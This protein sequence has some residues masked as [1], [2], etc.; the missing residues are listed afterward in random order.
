VLDNECVAPPVTETQIIVVPRI[1]TISPWSS[2]AT[3]IAHRCNLTNVQRIERGVVFNLE[4]A[5]SLEATRSE[6]RVISLL[7]DRMTESIL[8]DHQQVAE[9]FNRDAP[10]P[11]AEIELSVD[12]HDRLQRAN[13]VLGLALSPDEIDYLL[14]AYRRLQRNPTDAELM[15]FAQ[16]NSEHCRHKIF[17]ASFTLDGVAQADSL[18]AM[19]RHT[20]TLSPAGVLSA[21]HDNSA[22]IEGGP[23]A[24][25]M[26]QADGHYAAVVEPVHIQIKVETHNHPTAISPFAGAA[27]GAGGEIRDEG[28]TGN[29]AKPKAG[30]CGYTVSNLELDG[31]RQPWE[32]P[33]G[34]PARIAAARDIMLEGPIGAAAFNNEFGRPNLGGFFRTFCLDIR[35]EG[36]SPDIRGYHKPIMIA[37]GFGSIRATNIDKQPVPAGAALVVL[38]GPA[39][40]IGLGGG[41]AS[42]MSSGASDEQLDFASVQRG[43]PEMQRRC[44]EVIDR[45]VALGP[46]SP[47]LSMHDVGAGGLSNAMPE[48]VNDAGR[49]ARIELRDVPNDEPGMSPCV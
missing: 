28:A 32:A 37:G 19:I 42:S 16:A 38:G 9:L 29:G 46:D 23:A 31:W 40:Q 30:L 24:R 14:D 5:H 12:A 11:F 36:D 26:I 22:V 48:L 10:V 8:W 39:M 45:C 33:V 41:A 47:I 1:G 18:F 21:Y 4:S 13:E 2:K 17:N 44:Q 25:W 43:N 20:H 15:M 34:K 7:H 3:E 35:S 27:T 49:G 6:Q